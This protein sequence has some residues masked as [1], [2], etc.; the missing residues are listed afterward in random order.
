MPE[1][2]RRNVLTGLTETYRAVAVDDLHSID[3]MTEVIS[4]LAA[5]S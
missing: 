4:D 2:S 5:F 3:A 1:G